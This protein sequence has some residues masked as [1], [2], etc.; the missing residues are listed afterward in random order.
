[1]R[2]DPLP[3]RAERDGRVEYPDAAAGQPVER[4]GSRRR[5]PADGADAV[6]GWP[7]HHRGGGLFRLDGRGAG[8]CVGRAGRGAAR[9]GARGPGRDAD[10]RPTALTLYLDGRTITA[11]RDSS[12]WTVEKWGHAWGVPAEPLPY[13]PRLD[14]PF[15]S[16]R[17]TR[18]VMNLQDQATRALI[19]LEA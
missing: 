10:D 17:I 11:E 4:D 19:R 1:G 6:P 3:G 13:R 15:G 12:G 14:R 8:A 18:E 2:A 5:R 9:P 7:H 16:S